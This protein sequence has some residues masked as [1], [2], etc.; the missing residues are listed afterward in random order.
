MS[1]G[2][3]KPAKLIERIYRASVFAPI[4]RE[5]VGVRLMATLFHRGSA[6]LYL[7]YAIWGIASAIF[8][9]PSLIETHGHLWQIGFSFLVFMACAPAAVGATFFPKLARLEMF[10]ASAF[11]GL[12][13]LYIGTLIVSGIVGHDP[14]R[15][16]SAILIGTVLI[17]PAIRVIFIYY[18]LI[19]NEENRKML[20]DI[21][22]RVERGP[23]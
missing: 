18:A 22:K 14:G 21:L 19:K 11:V 15:P 17:F 16:I 7:G 20:G 2:D 6:T 10:M 9:I 8:G 3:T 13:V 1:L 23:E 5:L 4:T 12:I